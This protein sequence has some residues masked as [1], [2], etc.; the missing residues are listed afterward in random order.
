[1]PCCAPAEQAGKFDGVHIKPIK[2]PSSEM[3]LQPYQDIH[4]SGLDISKQAHGMGTRMWQ[5]TLQSEM[6]H[7]TWEDIPTGLS[8]SNFVIACMQVNLHSS[9]ASHT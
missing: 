2:Y 9:L 7:A 5:S 1:M 6:M 3:Q 8:A 4:T